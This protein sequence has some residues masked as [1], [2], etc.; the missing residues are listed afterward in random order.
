MIKLTFLLFTTCI[1]S[2]TLFSQKGPGGVGN[3]TTN[4]M[5][6]KA[7]QGASSYIHNTAIESWKDCS[8]NNIVV[9]QT[10]PNKRPIFSSNTMNGYPAIKFDKTDGKNHLLSGAADNLNGT[11]GVTIFSVVQKQG[12]SVEARSIISK[13]TNVDV[14]HSFMFFFYTKNS[15]FIDYEGTNNRF[16]TAETFVNNETLLVSTTF[17]GTLPAETRAS[18]YQGNTL[19]K[20]S[21]E[22]STQIANNI[23]PVVIGA[24][25]T[26]DIREFKGLIA[27]VITYK[28]ALNQTQRIIVNNYLSA[29]YNVNLTHYDLY[30]MDNTS[31]GNF[32]HEVAGIGYLTDTDKHLVAQGSGIIEISN[33]TNLKEKFLLWGHNNGVQQAVNTSDVPTTVQARFDR[34]WRTSSVTKDDTPANVGTISMQFDLTSLGNVDPSQLR[35]LISNN[36]NFANSIPLSGATHVSGNLY[37][38]D[39]VSLENGNYFTLGTTNRTATPLPITLIDFTA[40]KERRTVLLNWS[41]ASEENNERFEIERTID[42]INWEVIQTVAG[43]GNSNTAITYAGIDRKPTNGTNYYRLKQVDFNGTTTVSTVRSV[44]FEVPIALSVYPNPATDYVTINRG[45]NSNIQLINDLGQNVFSSI[46]SS[47]SSTVLDV[48][49]LKSGVYFIRL[50]EDEEIIT[51]K[52]ILMK[53]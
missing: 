27:E 1:L 30:K 6:L 4:S 33:A 47:E 2:T 53:D 7:N 34:V 20:A 24:T 48:S 41:T 25:H 37:R 5:W 46:E 15:L 26:T 11:N 49:N 52:L 12:P 21:M 8:G 19:L 43:S 28:V 32:D 10:E 23:A 50:Q 45:L 16:S 13:R 14:N 31:D 35:L 38:F 51:R 9:N 17:D 22:N 44:V 29:K 42:G 36:V 18:I 3:S 40:S 39:F